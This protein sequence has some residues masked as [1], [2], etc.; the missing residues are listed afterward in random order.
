MPKFILQRS[1]Y[2]ARERPSKAYSWPAFLFASI[3]AEI[4]YHIVIGVL[5]WAGFYFP[6]FG[7]DQSSGRQ[8]LMV[9]Y[10]VQLSLFASTFAQFI[11]ASLPDA[12]ITGATFAF[13]FIVTFNGVLQPPDAL[14]GFWIFMYRV[15]PL[16]YLVSGIT[17]TG[18]HDRAVH[19]S[20]T[21]VNAFNPPPGMTCGEY[22]APYLETSTGQLY[23]P[24]AL[25][26]CQY[27][28]LETADQIL[29]ISKYCKF[30]MSCLMKQSLLINRAGMN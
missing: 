13:I 22:L 21:E 1:Y 20:S 25:V 23:N 4:P 15:S 27:C 8:G 10:L 9:L 16:T 6:V 28:P 19:C 14:P 12:D 30:S 26:S 7:Q 29:A 2:E 24:S 18:L 3:F 17:A 11:T 5:A